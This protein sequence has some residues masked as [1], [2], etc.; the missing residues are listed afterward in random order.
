MFIQPPV[1]GDR[2]RPLGQEPVGELLGLGLELCGG[3]GDWQPLDYRIEHVA[4]GEGRRL[5]RQAGGAGQLGQDRVDLGSSRRPASL[6]AADLREPLDGNA[7]L[8]QLPLPA[9]IQL[10][11][12][13]GV[14]LG[15]P[16]GDCRSARRLDPGQPVLGEPVVDLL[17]PLWDRLENASIS[18]R[19]SNPMISAA[20]ERRSTAVQRTPAGGSARPAR[21]P[22]RGGRRPSGE[23]RPSTAARR[24]NRAQAA[25][26]RVRKLRQGR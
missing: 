22:G 17:G 11:L 18:C 26:R 8:G 1:P 13:L 5:R 7:A 3:G 10:L 2:D 20:P 9:G 19:S 6:V 4:A 12:G 15:L 21:P 14:L 25:A 23:G 16:G 24:L